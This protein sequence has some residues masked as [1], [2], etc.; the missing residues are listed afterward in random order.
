M[1]LLKSNLTKVIL[2]LIANYNFA[3]EIKIKKG[4]VS[5]DN[6]EVAMMEKKKLIYS[7]STLNNVPKFSVQLN[8][9]NML[10][11]SSIYWCLLTDLQT[12]KTNEILDKSQSYN[13]SFE[14]GIIS[15][16]VHGDVKFITTNGIDEKLV[17]E[18]I[19]GP[20]SSVL[21][22]FEDQDIKTISELLTEK[23][24]L[25]KLKIRIEKSTILQ[26]QNVIDQ[27]GNK[28]W[29]DVVVGYIEKKEQVVVQGFP[30]IA[31]F[32][33]NSSE[34]IPDSRGKNQEIV[35]PIANW[36]KKNDA[37]DNPV[38]GKRIKEQI[39]TIDKK[40]F[41]LAE[42]HP[43]NQASP[44]NHSMFGKPDENK[45]KEAIVAKLVFN[46]YSIGKPIE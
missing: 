5:L 23:K 26:K 16:V 29:K 11:G 33:V 44:E 43:E 45:L 22:D 8:S 18:F 9:R 42:I 1:K 14:K 17:T 12:N 36:F 31:S 15:S 34:I 21:K 10:D 30:P 19:N 6:I 7:F 37:Y 38:T 46:G 25:E 13:L 24:N 20:K 27:Q 28:V 4:I 32:A 39:I 2:L 3:Q 35:K 41:N 40:S